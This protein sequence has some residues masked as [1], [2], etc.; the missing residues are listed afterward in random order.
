MVGLRNA[1]LRRPDVF[2]QT[3]TEKLLLYAIGRGLTP[4]DMPAVRAIVRNARANGYRFS[5]LVEGIVS[6]AAFTMREKEAPEN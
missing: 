6:S 3:L 2:V 5:S 4:E 1:L